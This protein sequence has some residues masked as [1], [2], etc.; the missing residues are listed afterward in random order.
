MEMA[1]VLGILVVHLVA[2]EAQGRVTRL[3][4]EEGVVAE[5]IN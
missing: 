4:V 2:P 5:V 3:V 1:I